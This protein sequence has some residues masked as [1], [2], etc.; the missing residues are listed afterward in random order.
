M[1]CV[2]VGLLVIYHMFQNQPVNVAM[3]SLKVSDC[4]MESGRRLL[5]CEEVNHIGSELH[6]NPVQCL[7]MVAKKSAL[8]VNALV[9]TYVLVNGFW[10]CLLE[11]PDV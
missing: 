7:V 5:G 9:L 3:A 4:N 8:V 2:P 1:A 11:L 6:R 10:E